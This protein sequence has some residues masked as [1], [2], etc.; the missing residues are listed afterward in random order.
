M[1][2]TTQY[3]NAKF[4]EFNKTYFS[5]EIKK[6][7]PIVVSRTT[8]QLGHVTYNRATLAVSKFAISGAF[9]WEGFEKNLDETIL[10][11]MI[12]VYEAQILMKTPDHS[13]N[14]IKKMNEINSDGWNVTITSKEK[15]LKAIKKS[16]FVLIESPTESWITFTTKGH[17]ITTLKFYKKRYGDYS[18]SY[19]EAEHKSTYTVKRSGF[20]RYRFNEG[21]KDI[22]FIA[23]HSI[24]DINIKAVHAESLYGNLWE[25]STKKFC[26]VVTSEE[27][28]KS[29][30]PSDVLVNVN[31]LE[32]DMLTKSFSDLRRMLDHN[33]LC[34]FFDIDK[35]LLDDY[36]FGRTSR[37]RFR[38]NKGQI[39]VVA[40]FRLPN[41]ETKEFYKEVNFE[42]PV[43]KTIYDFEYKTHLLVA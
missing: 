5:G 1:K 13:T 8:R 25:V 3:I 38:Y 26:L 12:H 14:F 29:V 41:G 11:E 34:E 42:E 18:I 17:L 36:G 33:Y 15:E 39:A 19:G 9:N 23:K 2:L 7:F 27:E 37:V 10:H 43:F 35:E 32:I 31:N 21:D 24:E 22:N 28:P 16:S 6:V 20:T 40:V 30:R 4:D